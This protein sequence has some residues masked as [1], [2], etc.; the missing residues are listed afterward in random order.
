MLPALL[1]TFGLAFFWFIGAI[2]A[3]IGLGLPPAAA[4]LTAWLSYSSGAIII[5]LVGAPLR[6]RIIKRFNLKLEPNPKQ[7]LWWAWNRFGLVGLAILAPITT[8]SQ[9]AALIGLTLGEPATRLVVALTAGGA[10]W[11]AII[12]MLIALGVQIAS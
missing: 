2:P 6:E 7:P 12:A 1:S 10:L 8:G 4:A 3:G 9:I 11:S 5:A